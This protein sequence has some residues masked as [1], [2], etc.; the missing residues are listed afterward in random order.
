MNGVALQPRAIEAE[1]SVLGSILGDAT[2]IDK[3][4]NVLHMKEIF[5]DPR[6][7][8]IWGHILK[9]KKDREVVDPVTLLAQINEK[10]REDIGGAYYLSELI[11]SNVSSSQISRH[12]EI[13]LKKWLQ[14]KTIKCQKPPKDT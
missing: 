5:Y 2:L 12:S 6:H 3:V 13:V 4:I 11:D 10:E 14:R 7:Q 1:Q 9:M 8:E